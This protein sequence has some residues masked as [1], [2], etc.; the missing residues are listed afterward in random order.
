MG[1]QL[2]FVHSYYHTSKGKV[3]T[4]DPQCH[5]LKYMHVLTWP[6]V[7]LIEHAYMYVHVLV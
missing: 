4:V 7:V 2:H 6:C 1:G 5:V 3:H